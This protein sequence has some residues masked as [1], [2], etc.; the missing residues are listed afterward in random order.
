MEVKLDS[1]IEK[2]KSEGV[3]GAQKESNEI[4][5]KAKKDAADIV[6]KAKKEAEEMAAKAEAKAK[7]FQVNAELAIQQAARDGELLFKGKITA[8]FDA[9]FK[10]QVKSALTPDFMKEMILKIIADWKEPKVEVTV[11][12]GDQAKLEKIL[13]DEIKEDVKKGI[14][15]KPSSNVEAG[16]QIGL[17]NENVYYDFTDDSIAAILKSFLNPR[18]NEI[19]G[20]K[21]G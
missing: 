5:E 8:L 17:Q 13:F 20:K 1:L 12:E 14:M 6:A 10:R 15:I 16:F 21:N 9:V 11:S 19:L 2:I 4:I 7:D 18:L 3:E